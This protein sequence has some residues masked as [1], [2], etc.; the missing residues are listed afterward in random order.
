MALPQAAYEVSKQRLT[1][2]HAHRTL[3][4]AEIYSPNEQAIEAGWLDRIVP[5]GQLIATARAKAVELGGLNMQAFVAN[6][7]RGRAEAVEALRAAIDA[8]FPAATQG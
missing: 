7:Q 4:L 3:A 6:K 8:E 5:P 2:A 1:P